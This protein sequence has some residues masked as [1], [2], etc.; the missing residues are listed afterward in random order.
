MRLV[1][2][3]SHGNGTGKTSL[4]TSVARHWPDRFAAVKFTTVVQDGKFCPRDVAK[5]CAC[6]QLHDDYSVIDDLATLDVENTDTGRMLAAGLAPVRWCLAKPDTHAAAWEHLRELIPESTELLTEGNTAMHVVPSDR[7]VFVVNPRV[8]RAAWKPDWAELAQR[9]SVVII[10]EA[11][12]ALG[13]RRPA[14]DE[15]CEAALAEVHEATPGLPRVVA[16]FDAPFADWA[17][18]LVESIFDGS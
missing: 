4:M 17:G 10:N 16:R 11:P 8:P 7:L 14:S 6:T 9:S 1:G 15:D 13:R 12:E 18:P 3:V 5:S 2:I